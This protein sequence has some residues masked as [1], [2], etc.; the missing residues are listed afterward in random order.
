MKTFQR[1]F[2]RTKKSNTLKKVLYEG[3][4][5]KIHECAKTKDDSRY[6]WEKKW[7]IG[8]GK[9]KKKPTATQ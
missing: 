3:R 9:G 6:S 1:E 2:Q 5:R 8:K 4:V 7:K